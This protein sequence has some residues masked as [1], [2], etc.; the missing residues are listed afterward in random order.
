MLPERDSVFVAQ[1]IGMR[2]VVVHDY[3]DVD[4]GL[5]W[6]TVHDDLPAL[7]ARLRGLLDK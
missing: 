5:V 1:M 3:A 4:L 2:I 6:K 7:T